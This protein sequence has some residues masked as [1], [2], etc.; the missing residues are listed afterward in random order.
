M[1]VIQPVLLIFPIS[2][3]NLATIVRYLTSFLTCKRFIFRYFYLSAICG[4]ITGHRDGTLLF[5]GTVISQELSHRIF[6]IFLCR[7]LFVCHIKRN[8]KKLERAE[9][10]C[11]TKYINIWRLICKTPIPKLLFLIKSSTK[12]IKKIWQSYSPVLLIFV[13]SVQKFGDDRTSFN[14]F[15]DVCGV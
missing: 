13:I 5:E 3:P 10:W 2:V 15:F 4:D 12:K 7:H 8:N 11:H 6:S 1:A 9:K 14:V